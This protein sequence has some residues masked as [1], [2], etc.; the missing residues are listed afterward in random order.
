MYELSIE[1]V[2]KSLLQHQ[3]QFEFNGRQTKAGRLVL[4][5]F[6]HHNIVFRIVEDGTIR[7]QQSEYKVPYPFSVDS[8]VINRTVVFNY[9]L[10]H[11]FGS[12]SKLVVSAAQYAQSH[13]PSRFYNNKLT[14]RIQ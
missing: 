8:S 4:F 7:G 3:V 14:I 12:S 2:L 10:S 13:K 11:L 9:A 5:N 1:P 6:H